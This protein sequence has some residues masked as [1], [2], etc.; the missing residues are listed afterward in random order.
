MLASPPRLALPSR[1]T[2]YREWVRESKPAIFVGATQDWPALGKWSFSWFH[3]VH[4]DLAVAV[5]PGLYERGPDAGTAKRVGR[6]RATTMREYIDALLEGAPRLRGDGTSRTPEVGYL[7]GP[8]VLNDAPRLRDDVPFPPYGGPAKL[9]DGSFWMGGPG[10]VTQLHM[11]RAHNLY[12]QVVGRKR[13]QLYSPARSASLRGRFVHWAASVSDLEL[14]PE[15]FE[16]RGDLTPDYEFDIAPGEMLFLPYGWWHRVTTLEAAIAANLWW[17]T[18]P[19]I[20]TH[21]PDVVRSIWRMRRQ[22]GLRVGRSE[23]PRD[24]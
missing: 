21:G 17:W 13:W 3:E 24:G 10:T 20:V 19:M 5:H 8:D 6:F 1:R 23:L 14:V 7:A 22:R 11:D 9:A 15:P 4:G 18:I 2:F 12:V 16:A